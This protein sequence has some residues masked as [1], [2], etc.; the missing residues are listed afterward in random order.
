MTQFPSKR[1]VRKIGKAIIGGLGRSKKNMKTSNKNSKDLD[2]FQENPA[3]ESGSFTSGT[4]ERDLFCPLSSTS[5][6]DRAPMLVDETQVS[7]RPT[8]PT[9]RTPLEKGSSWLF[10]SSLK[11]EDDS[12][13]AEESEAEEDRFDMVPPLPALKA[14]VKVDRRSAF[15]RED[16]WL[17]M[18]T[19]LEKLLS[20]AA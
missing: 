3:T 9:C 8:S 5:F 6:P 11:V 2:V 10:L 14:K 20:K 1:S 19:D 4:E 12:S 15:L 16:S 7:P 17:S 18:D 13:S